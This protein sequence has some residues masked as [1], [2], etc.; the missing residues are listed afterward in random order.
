MNTLRAGIIGCGK[1]ASDFA[2]DPKMQGDIFSHAEAYTTFPGAELAAICDIDEDQ[3]SKCGRRWG[4]EARYQ[5]VRAM[6]AE[7]HLD[8][9]SVCTPDNTHYAILKEILT[10][11]KAL[12]AILCEKP[13]AATVEQSQELVALTRQRGIILAVVYLRRFASNMRALK[14]FIE[15]GHLGKIQAVA[16]WYT[17]G[18]RHNGSHWID[19]L[20]F[21]VGEVDWVQ[22]WD[23]IQDDP[24]DPTLD[25]VLGLEN[26][27]IATLRAAEV[28][29]FTIF[30]ME[31]L[32]SLGRVRLTDS[33]YVVEYSRA[34]A[35]KR[36]TGYR[37]LENIPKNFG[38]RKDVMYHAVENLVSAIQTGSP[39][40]CT[41]EDG[42]AVI[43]IASAAIQSAQQGKKLLSIKEHGSWE[44]PCSL[45]QLFMKAQPTPPTI[46]ALSGDPG[47]ASAVGPVIKRL[48]SD[49]RVQ[50][51]ALAYNET[52]QIWDNL[53][54]AYN[55]LS[56]EIPD[57]EILA[58]LQRRDVKLLFTGT[59]VNPVDL[60][61]RFIAAA[62]RIGLPSLA[63]LDFWLNYRLR[64]SNAAGELAFMPN[65]I[66]VMDA[67]ARD[68]MIRE[69]FD[70]ARIVITGQPT[71]DD[72]ADWRQRFSP[73]LREEIRAAIGIQPDELFVLF[74][75]Q[76]Q[77]SLYG[78]D[79]INGDHIGFDEWDVL[80][81]LIKALENLQHQNDAKIH[82]VVRPHPRETMELFQGFHSNQI[83]ITV[84]TEGGARNQV[85]AADL[86]VGMNTELLVE[87]C[88]LGCITLSLQ[89]N[90]RHI[91]KL[92]TNRVGVSRAVYRYEDIQPALSELL[93]DANVRQRM[94]EKLESY[95]LESKAAGKVA[96]LIYDMIQ[97]RGAL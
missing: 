90:L 81:A 30:E 33:G 88:Y 57:Q 93:F 59:S 45:C 85:M 63:L 10:A 53:G 4:V 36:Y 96:Q 71:F 84:T 3:L 42:L 83:I 62:S 54:I 25:L 29:F 19:L 65:K 1:I 11:P 26:G 15:T 94:F 27:V 56:G 35:S 92:P 31:I 20:R 66:A 6:L 7:A 46:I 64:F 76:P 23:R 21:L 72:L 37:E 69:G 41:G 16:G 67:L 77:S 13:L 40:A 97:A 18:I 50:V 55:K 5:D 89:P 91:D 12:K 43:Q 86:V 9:I 74:P 47:G 22:A 49:Q 17:K 75:S 60:E 32:G 61:K 87:A 68:E 24:D 14:D 34:A 73:Q 51:E 52:A 2:D 95:K 70:P 82:L 80:K 38:D 48:Q 79:K 58:F 78:D 8:M 28:K 44:E 39:V